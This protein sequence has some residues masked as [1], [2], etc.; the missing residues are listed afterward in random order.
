MM[1]VEPENIQRPSSPSQFIGGIQNAMVNGRL[2][3]NV[4]FEM[5]PYYW[6]NP[7]K[8]S[9][10]FEA[11]EYL[12]PEKSVFSTIYKTFT[13]SFGTS[14]SDTIVFGKL[15]PGTGLGAGL[16]FTIID[17]KPQ[18]E[19]INRLM[20]WNR[21]FHRQAVLITII[22]NITTKDADVTNEKIIENAIN[23][24]LRNIGNEKSIYN[25]AGLYDTDEFVKEVRSDVSKFSHLKDADFLDSLGSVIKMADKEESKL[26]AAINKSKLPFAKTGF[27]LEFAAGSAFIFQNNSLDSGKHAKTSVWLTPSYRW[28]LNKDGDNISLLDVAGVLRLTFNNKKDSVDVANYLDAGIKFQYTHNRWSLSAEGVY[29]HASKVPEGVK[30]KY[31][32]RFVTSLDYKMSDAV[33]FKFSFGSNFDGNTATYTDPKKMFAAGGLNLGIFNSQDKKNK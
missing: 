2:K 18:G 5:T 14:E 11:R 20:K 21:L 15:K 9:S 10:R 6:K 26:L 25:L 4:A 16:R 32:Y 28:E 13:L 29:R 24:Y 23:N 1:G 17:G 31:T 30:K 12:L 8:D 33:T 27:I 22:D 7:K 3:P 19:N